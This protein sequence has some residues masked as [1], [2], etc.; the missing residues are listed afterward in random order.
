MFEYILAGFSGSFFS[1]FC[2]FWVGA[3]ANA[4]AVGTSSERIIRVVNRHND[5]VESKL[6]NIMKKIS[7]DSTRVETQVVRAPQGLRPKW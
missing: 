3:E 5:S 7:K 2:A 4:F 6:D 1:Y